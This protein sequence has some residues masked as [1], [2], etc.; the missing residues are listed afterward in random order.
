MGIFDI[1]SKLM[2]THLGFVQQ[3]LLG[4]LSYGIQMRTQFLFGHSYSLSSRGNVC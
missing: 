1:S 4:Y 3:V 2:K